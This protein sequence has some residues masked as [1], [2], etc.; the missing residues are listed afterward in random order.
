MKSIHQI[1]TK[2]IELFD[3]YRPNI[4]QIQSMIPLTGIIRHT[5]AQLRRCW[6]MKTVPSTL[7][8]FQTWDFVDLLQVL[9]PLLNNCYLITI[10]ASWIFSSAITKTMYSMYVLSKLYKIAPNDLAVF[11]ISVPIRLKISAKQCWNLICFV[12]FIF[13]LYLKGFEFI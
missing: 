13:I 10:L 7:R 2:T 6:L 3:L 8:S 1:R 12:I 5:V 4:C 11:E 9:S